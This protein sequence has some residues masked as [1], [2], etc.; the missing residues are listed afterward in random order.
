MENLEHD[1]GVDRDGLRQFQRVAARQRIVEHAENGCNEKAADQHDVPDQIP[2]QQRRIT[3]ARRARHCAGLRGFKGQRQ[4]Q[5][6]AADQID[7]QHLHGRDRQGKAEKQRQNDRQGLT[8]I[9]RQR[10]ADHLLQIVPHRAPFAHSGGDGGEIVVGKHQIGGFLGRF[11][12]LQPHGNARIGTLQGRGII[13][14]VSRHG[15]GE[16][17]RLQGR[18]Q[19]Q[20]VLG[21]GAGEDIAIHHFHGKLRV[22]QPV[23]IRAGE[24]PVRIFKSDLPGDGRRRSGVVAGDHLHPDSGRPAF[25]HGL[26]RLRTRRVDQPGQAQERQASVK[27]VPV[28]FRTRLVPHG[29]GQNTQTPFCHGFGPVMPV[30]QVNP[31]AHAQHPLRRSLHMGDAL[32]AGLRQDRHIA[33]AAVER[34]DIQPLGIDL[35]RSLARQRKQ[36]PFHRIALDDPVPGLAGKGRIVAKRR[37]PGELR[38]ISARLDRPGGGIAVA[39]HLEHAVRCL[40]ADNRHLVAGQGSGL[41][42]ADHRD[43]TDGLDGRKAADDGMALRHGPDADGQRDGGDRRQAFR[44]GG[45]SHADNRHEQGCKRMAAEEIPPGQQDRGGQNDQQREPAGKVIHLLHERRLQGLHA[46][47]KPADAADFRMRTRCHH[48][49]APGTLR[50]QR[51]GPEH[52]P[53]VPQRCILR[54]RGGGLVR[55]NRFAGQDGFLRAQPM[56]LQQP[57]IRR[58]LVPGLQQH[59]IA[60][61]QRRAIHRNALP[62]AQ[63]SRPRRQHAAD[64]G[65]R[66]LRLAF[67][68][69]ADHGIAR[70]HCQNDG[71]VDPVLQQGRHHSRPQQHIDQ[72][73][74]ELGEETDKRAAA[75]RLGQ[76]VGAVGFQAAGRLFRGQPP[77]ACGQ[78]IK[79]GLCGLAV[80][81]GQG[82]AVSGSFVIRCQRAL[83]P[84]DSLFRSFLRPWRGLPRQFQGSRSAPPPRHRTA[85]LLPGPPHPGTAPAPD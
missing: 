75:W 63:D 34:D 26:D 44:N 51:A 24:H 77:G 46:G 6:H 68:Q 76:A 60:W 81:R 35:A 56:G 73:I 84:C 54:H 29:K 8:G 25:G 36:R 53:P 79:A 20:L 27:V 41:V 14:P 10:P 45:H 55:G 66:R 28:D 7:P 59:D 13:H 80:R 57:Q 9:G 69:E 17:P 12:A 19:P 11:R 32:A 48:E 74:A 85:A 50:H 47:Q 15:H 71:G 23:E 82:H 18:N 33:V 49:A 5:C 42:G 30:R 83:P 43:R 38:E 40:D 39:F 58:H 61:H 37:R 2:R 70:H 65:H 16:A 31:V 52:G 21:A 67:L 62:A 22:I 4:P 72:H 3:A 1:N 78:L 64:G